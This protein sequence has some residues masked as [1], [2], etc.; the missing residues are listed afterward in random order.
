MTTYVMVLELLFGDD[1]CHLQGVDE[2]LEAMMSIA[3]HKDCIQP[4]Y[5]ANVVWKVIDDG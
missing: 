4:N 2:V 1:N 3:L 5:Y